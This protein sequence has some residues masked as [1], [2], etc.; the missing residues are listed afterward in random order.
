MVQ[1]SSGQ[2]DQKTEQAAGG[3]NV[4]HSSPEGAGPNLHRMREGGAFHWRWVGMRKD[5]G[6][7]K[8]MATLWAHFK[9]R[10]TRNPAV[11]A[12]LCKTDKMDD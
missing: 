4:E 9:Q 11:S 7:R 2:G 6:R 8:A 1:V 3:E 12:Q 10:F 5:K